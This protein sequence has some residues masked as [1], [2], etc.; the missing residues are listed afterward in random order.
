MGRVSR[1]FR[2]SLLLFF[3]LAATPALGAPEAGDGG[4]TG[5][6]ADHWTFL[7]VAAPALRQN[8]CG[9]FG[10]TFIEKQPVSHGVHIPMALLVLLVC[11]TMALII[12]RGLARSKDPVVPDARFGIRTFFELLLEFVLETMSAIMGEKRARQYLPFIGGL[13]VFILFSNLAGLVPGLLPPT[14]SLN[15]TLALGTLVFFATHIAGVREQGLAYG[16]H[17]LGP[18]IKWYALP[19]ML[20]MLIIEVISH[21]VRPMSLALR[22]MG[23]MVGKH[24]VVVIFLSFNILFV[25]LPIMA[26][27]ILVAAVQTFVFCLLSTIYLSLALE[28]GEDH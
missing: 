18:I 6:F 26:L 14:E 17:F 28:H 24:K 4:Q 12:R 7:D 15:T 3:L 21:L 23:N 27:G 22:L 1:A 13:A 10:T 19:L 11:V 2:G 8:L 25:P 16:K 9:V 5:C 20:I